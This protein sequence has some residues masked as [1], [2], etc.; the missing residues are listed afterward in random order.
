MEEK[1][2]LSVCIQA[3]GESRRMGQN[4][5]LIPFL[6]KPLIQRVIERV[7]AI[8]SEILIITNDPLAYE[9]IHLPAIADSIPGHGVLGGLYTSLLTSGQPFVASIACDMPF[10][11]P[12]LLKIEYDLL[13]ANAADVVVPESTNGLEPLHAVYRRDSCL[14]FVKQAIEQDERRLISW[15]HQVKVRILSRAEMAAVGPD[16]MAFININTPA[17]FAFAEA[18]ALANTHTD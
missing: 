18:L 12:N 2:M 14:P 16:E 3:G 9:F 1:L 8:A 13:L 4:K 6:G 7:A 15:F 5:A 17:E 10:V 11:S